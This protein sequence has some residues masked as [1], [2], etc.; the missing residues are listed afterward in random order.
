MSNVTSI[1]SDRYG[2]RGLTILFWSLCSIIGFSMFL[3][4]TVSHIR[5]GAIFLLLP[6]TYCAAPPL[7][8]WVANNSAPHV[9]R[10]T[11]LAIFLI[12]TNS[13]GILATWLLGSLSPAPKYT[14]ASITLL[15]FNIGLFVCTAA[16]LA[17]LVM[18]NKEKKRLREEGETSEGQ[19]GLG[20][21]GVD[22]KYLL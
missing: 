12:M 5:Y 7:Q 22:Y 10:A 17:Y 14:K 4:S 19:H 11:A 15:I 3:G 21:D 9:R 8:T 13:G 2:C 20:D 18:R 16:N 6:G 1:I